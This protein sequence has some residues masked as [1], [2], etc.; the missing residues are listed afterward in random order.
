MTCVALDVYFRF[1]YFLIL[2]GSVSSAGV[3]IMLEKQK[4]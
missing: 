3:A 4:G 2:D 1:S